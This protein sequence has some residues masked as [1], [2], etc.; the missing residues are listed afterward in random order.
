MPHIRMRS[1]PSALCIAFAAGAARGQDAPPPDASRDPAAT[2]LNERLAAYEE[3]DRARQLVDRGEWDQAAQRFQS[4]VDNHGDTL[5]RRGAAP[6][7]RPRSDDLEGFVNLPERV[8]AELIEGPPRLLAEYLRRYEATARDAIRRES[9]EQIGVPASAW[10]YF[11]TAAAADAIEAAA[12]RLMEAGRLAA[13]ARLYRR[14]ASSHPLRAAREWNWQAKLALCESL[15]GR[16]DA[17]D[18]LK[19]RLAA[20]D[21][22]PTVTWGGKQQPLQAFLEQFV[23]A[24]PTPKPSVTLGRHPFGGDSDGRISLAETPAAQA[25]LWRCAYERRKPGTSADTWDDDDQ[26]L[27]D[28]TRRTLRSGRQLSSLPLAAD[29]LIVLANGRDV[30]AV[31]PES[32]ES[33]VWRFARPVEADV[34]LAEDRWFI[35]D[36]AVPL[37]TVTLGNGVVF[38]AIERSDDDADTHAR[39]DPDAARLVCLDLRTGRCI[40]RNTLDELS[41]PF[42]ECR[43]DGAPLVLDD[44]VVAVVRRRKPFGFE[45]CLLACF[46]AATG[47]LLWRTHLGEAATGGYGYHKPTQ[48]FPTAIDGRIFIHTNIGTMAAVDAEDGRVA[49]L[50]RY[51]TAYGRAASDFAAGRPERAC[52]AWHYTSAMIWGDRVV[53]APLDASEAFV[54]AQDDGAPAER[55]AYERLRQPQSFLGV[56]GDRLYCVGTRI[57]CFD[58]AAR[59]IAWERPLADGSLLGRGALTADAALIPTDVG[60][61]RYPLDGGAPVTHAWSPRAAGNVAAAAGRILVASGQSVFELGDKEAA[62]ARLSSRAADRPTD[63]RPLLSLAELAFETSDYERG[64]ASLDQAMERGRAAHGAVDDATRARVYGL[65]LRYAQRLHRTA[66]SARAAPDEELDW[67]HGMLDRAGMCAPDEDAHVSFR[68]LRSELFLAAGRPADAVDA[69]QQILTDPALARRTLT[70]ERSG[71]IT[72]GGFARDRIARL[73]FEHGRAVYANV[74]QKAEERLRIAWAERNADGLL[75]VAERYPNSAAAPQ[76]LTRFAAMARR[77]GRL[78]DAVRALRRA[79]GYRDQVDRPAVLHRLAEALA[80]AGRREAARYWLD[81]AEREHGS[82]PV[83]VDGRTCSIDEFRRSLLGDGDAGGRLRPRPVFPLSS[84][85]ALRFPQPP[86][87]LDPEFAER[88]DAAWDGFAVFCDDQLQWYDAATG[89]PR[90]PAP[91][92]CDTR[93]RLL[94]ADARQAVF[95]TPHR[96]FAMDLARGVQRWSVGQKDDR[97]DPAADPEAFG[98]WTMMTAA[99]AHL[100][101]ATSHGELFA[102]RLTDGHVEWRIATS[103]RVGTRLTTDGTWIAYSGWEERRAVVGLVD[104][105]TGVLS[106]QVALASERPLQMLTF[107]DDGYLLAV[108][109][110]TAHAIEPRDGTI[111]W[112]AR[113]SGPAVVTS[114]CVGPDALFVS[115]DGVRLDRIDLLTGRLDWTSPP[116]A[117]AA[118]QSMRCRWVNDVLVCAGDETMA[119][120]DP[121]SGAILWEARDLRWSDA[122]SLIGLEDSVVVVTSGDGDPDNA[123]NADRPA[124]EAQPPAPVGGKAAEEDARKSQRW[125]VVRRL[126]PRSGREL[127]ISGAADAAEAERTLRHERGDGVY[128]RNGGLLIRS[129]TTLTGYVNSP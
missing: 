37:N 111:V 95:A 24:A 47:R 55:V 66:Q 72:A 40:W 87:V 49:W 21:P 93:P 110:T 36:E 34:E 7:S 46:D 88:T 61:L 127:P 116:L 112:T 33:A 43:L 65:C 26:P 48:S 84:G 11:P 90:W 50:W 6:A 68:L 113:L 4:I 97:D 42:E 108:T 70:T 23:S 86:M 3:L 105:A 10:R 103:P 56:A 45:A 83:S 91:L 126:E 117:P 125:L 124:A 94:F 57:V 71:E 128:V 28:A 15:C 60:L 98:Q 64:L 73:I 31:D 80:A 76:A 53:F 12:D 25:T 59:E 13:A 89:T 14:L 104:A 82:A 35:Q 100:F 1:V 2:Y 51:P 81:R 54:F 85:Y 122:A 44:R 69:Y 52:R 63:P 115:T 74:E 99:P 101:A 27:D 8:F 41:N 120:V 62:W 18:A 22:A 16:R 79:L 17:L 77:D 78:D 19:V 118:N 114:I 92:R 107:T 119:A 30:W 32:P 129:G 121:A 109:T 75:S 29:G 38:A 96:L 67:A 58:L 20:S 9:A 123:A 5:M 106:R 102:I 39:G